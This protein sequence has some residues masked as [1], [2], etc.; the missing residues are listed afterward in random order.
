[1]PGA[2]AY[3]PTTNEAW[4][5]SSALTDAG[6][7]LAAITIIDT[8]TYTVKATLS[9][10]AASAGYGPI[11][12]APDL[13]KAYVSSQTS[14]TGGFG[15]EID[16]VDLTSHAF[17]KV[18]SYQ[19][20]IDGALGMAYDPGSHKVFVSVDNAHYML[21]IDAT[22]DTLLATWPNSALG[23]AGIG[24]G[25]GSIALDPTGSELFLLTGDQNQYPMVA[26]M[27]TDGGLPF[28]VLG[29]RAAGWEKSTGLVVLTPDGGTTTGASDIGLSD[30]GAFMQLI[31]PGTFSL[32]S[33][34]TPVGVHVS[35]FN[36][37]VYIA[38]LD[39][40]GHQR[41]RSFLMDGTPVGSWLVYNSDLKM[42]DYIPVDPPSATGSATHALVNFQPATFGSSGGGATLDA[43]TEITID[44]GAASAAPCP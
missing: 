24:G 21:V 10:T 42:E 17:T 36:Q 26:T 8:T 40:C 7:N 5:A 9:L 11:V 30:G 28:D 16:E 12:F 38:V 32:P 33:G 39:A 19:T 43:I 27:P 37:R 34:D 22:T 31:D 14:Q 4:V 20:A 25:F 35:T 44:N 41:V 1:L 23:D 18:A 3:N 29:G 15:S 2:L 6:T 13:G